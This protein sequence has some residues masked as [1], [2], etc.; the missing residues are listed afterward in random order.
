[1]HSSTR[2]GLLLML[3]SACGSGH[4]TGPS[5]ES[6]GGSPP[7]GGARET[8]ASD[9]SARDGAHGAGEGSTPDAGSKND[10][11]SDAG[12]G[13]V[14]P[15]NDCPAGLGID[16]GFYT[17]TKEYFV[18][19]T[20]NDMNS[21]TSLAEAL[22]TLGAAT[23]LALVGGDCVTVENGSYDET[24]LV[25]TSGSADTCTGY[26]VFRAASQG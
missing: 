25:T 9:A 11:S 26:V 21:G 14:T 5:G 20:G 10:G 7:E 4:D 23:K 22:A 3:A 2:I 17:C 15:G 6:D 12:G 1:M 8:G 24:V 16:A 19:P 18:S 13:T